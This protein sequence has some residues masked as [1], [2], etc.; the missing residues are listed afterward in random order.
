M[1][2]LR[3]RRISLKSPHTISHT[4]AAKIATTKIA[5]KIATTQPPAFQSPE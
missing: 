2:G 5:S 4:S 3:K 1:T